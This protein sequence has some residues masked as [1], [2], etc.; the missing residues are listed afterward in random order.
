[1][2]FAMNP[3]AS[4]LGDR[5]PQEVIAATSGQL[6]SFIRTLGPERADQPPAP[7]KWSVREIICHLADCE[8]VFAY[9]LR[10]AVAEDH[11]VIQPFDQDKWA[12]V[13]SAYDAPSAL[14]VFSSLRHWNIAFIGALKPDAYT[15]ILT[16]PERGEMPF[17]ELVE[18]MAGHDI[19]HL[20]QIEAIAARAAH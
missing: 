13:Y 1:M 4:H 18:T 20:R 17:R 2:S 19:N 3:Y 12:K 6:A 9:R 16:H 8:I 5:D 7:G 10:Q 15:K 11:H 14:A